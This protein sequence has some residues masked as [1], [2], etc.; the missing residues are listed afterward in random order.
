M[1][2]RIIVTGITGFIGKNLLKT[3]AGNEN[4]YIC[5]VRKESNLAGLVKAENIEYR[6]TS[7]N[8]DELIGNFKDAD[9]VI[10]MIGQMG[11]YGVPYERFEKVNC[12]LTKEVVNACIAANVQQLVYVSTPG[13]QGFGKRLCNEEEPYA[14]RNPYEQTKVIAEQAVIDG[15]S[16]T[17][18]KYTILRPD[19]VYGPEDTRRIKMYKNIRDRKFVLTTSGKS[20]LCP[21]YVL[22]VAQGINKSIGNP[23]AY[24]GIFN[25]SSET[26]ITVQEYLD[27]I[28]GY[29]G[30]KILRFNIGYKL[31]I[32]FAS[33]IE[34]FY[35]RV[36]KKDAFVSK[37]KIDFL[38]MDHS[39]SCEKAK[40]LLGYHA[41]Y[42][43]KYGFAETMK[44]CKENQLL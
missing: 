8:Q 28:A 13:V 3:I 37:N 16:K 11:A 44:W 1:E 36:L 35:D 17:T 14:P 7:F 32:F 39:T 15:L 30:T 25:L 41:E 27:V 24:N 29:F 33:I 34:T 31:S 40:N 5:L 43:F 18:V 9:V 22:D 26:D 21:T 12:S 4:Q 20:H 23:A 6:V 10:H 19:F 42:S 38:A 2:M